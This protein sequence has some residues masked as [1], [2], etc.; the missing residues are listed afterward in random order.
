[1]VLG[2]VFAA[3]TAAGWQGEGKSVFL[4]P[5]DPDTHHP[6]P[7]TPSYETLQREARALGMTPVCIVGL[8][9]R[10]VNASRDASGIIRLS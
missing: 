5:C 8:L 7:I 10:D 1:V 3:L 9:Y 6:S 4:P 2:W